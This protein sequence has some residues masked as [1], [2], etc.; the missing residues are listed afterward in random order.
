[1]PLVTRLCRPLA[2]LLVALLG[3]GTA[4]ASAAVEIG[5]HSKEFGVTFPHAFVSLS[6]TL[7]ATGEPVSGNYG[8][9]VRHLIGPSVL[10][11][12]VQGVIVSE[13][14]NYVAGANRHFTMVLTD[15]QYRSVLDL[16]ER[17]RAMPQPSYSLRRRNCVSFV[18]E[19]A[20]LLGLQADPRG[21]M[22][23]P[24]AFLDRVREQNALLIDA[25][26]PTSTI[27]AETADPTR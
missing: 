26:S 21:L 16:V 12:N 18:A 14:D 5:F 10:L 24:K 6:G 11:G 7:D 8:F 23:R 1:M 9:T 15:D 3:L 19:V 13:G 20:T 4:P 25:S 22:R 2:F 27:T 17:W